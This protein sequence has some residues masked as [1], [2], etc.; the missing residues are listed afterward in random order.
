MYNQ[1]QTTKK[2]LGQRA[3]DNSL[4][5]AER[6]T[7]FKSKSFTPGPGEYVAPTAFGHYMSAKI[8]DDM[9]P[10]IVRP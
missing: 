5:S 4:G 3:A 9:I 7:Y 8:C 2:R 10:E 1:V 6:L